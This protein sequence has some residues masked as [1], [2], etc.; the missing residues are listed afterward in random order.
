MPRYE[1]KSVFVCFSVKQRQGYLSEGRSS[2]RGWES[3]K[4]LKKVMQR[5]SE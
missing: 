2:F 3:E 4:S 1:K 5:G